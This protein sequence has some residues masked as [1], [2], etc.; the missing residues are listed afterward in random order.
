MHLRYERS[1][2]W[3]ATGL[4][5]GCAVN[6]PVIRVGVDQQVQVDETLPLAVRE[7]TAGESL[8]RT[9]DTLEATGLIERGDEHVK[10]RRYA[11]AVGAYREAL[12]TLHAGPDVSPYRA[13]VRA[14]L[15]EAYY[16]WSGSLLRMGLYDD[17][18]VKA[19]L[20]AK[21]GHPDGN[22]RRKDARRRA[23]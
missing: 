14:R 21:Y 9:G 3:L 11:M 2:V 7:L 15:G 17:A 22:A 19:T 23:R 18:A 8:R 10:G 12:D 1:I 4:A 20:A 5:W 16:A 13:Q 6:T